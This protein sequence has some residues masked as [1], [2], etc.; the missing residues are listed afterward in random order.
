MTKV[1]ESLGPRAEVTVVDRPDAL[2]AAC[3]NLAEDGC[4]LHGRGTEAGIVRQ[5][6]DVMARLGIAAGTTLPWGEILDRIRGRVRPDDLDR[7]CGACPWLPLGH[8]KA[9]LARLDGPRT[10]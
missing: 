1:V 7:I 6:R 4:A 3:P 5:D 10:P 8:C 9:G 2:C